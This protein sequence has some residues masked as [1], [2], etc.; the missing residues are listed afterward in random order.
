[1]S[2]TLLLLAGVVLLYA[3]TRYIQRVKQDVYVLPCPPTG[4]ATWLWGHEKR[5]FDYES[6]EM[7]TKWMIVLGPLYKIKAALFH[8]DVIVAA[9]HAAVQHIFQYSDKYVKSPVFRPP[10]ANL[11]GKGLVWAEGDDHKKQRRIIAPAFSQENIK[12]M[13]DDV[14]ECAEKMENTLTNQLLSNNGNMTVNMVEKT[15]ACTLDIIGRVAFGHDFDAGHSTESL[16]IAASWHHH[17]NMGLTFG[18]FVAPLLVRTFPWIVKLPI[19]TLQAQ[20]TTKL[21]VTKL[22]NRILGRAAREG[23][24]GRDILSLLL[25]A[26]KQE[27]KVEDGLTP[28]QIVD[29]VNTFIMVGHETTAGTTNFTL[30]QLA[31]NPEMQKRLREEVQAL[32][33]DLNYDNIQKLE[34]LDA[35]VKEGLRLHPAS[36]HTERVVLED[37]VIPLSTPIRTSDGRTLTSLQVKAGQIFHIPFT[38]MQTNPVVWGADAHEFRPE[39]WI[40]PGGVPAPKDLP[41]G[42][43]GLVAFCDGPR[44]CIG[45]R[46]AILELK[47]MLAT[48]V[49]SIEFG[50][51]D[52]R[53][54]Q[55]ISP[56]LQPVVDGQGGVL[57]L[58]LSLAPHH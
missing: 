8:D 15:S 30:L 52:A 33:Y 56:T 41:H 23:T 4:E 43:S 36:P 19:S 54:E 48:L 35:V 53:I 1:M 44:M 22:A 55:R 27:K 34:Y 46:L 58:K 45:Y 13:S 29:N 16:E 18:G 26:Q 7:Y 25:N 9:D 42:W 2:S 39:R 5:V 32:Q 31:R 6:N 57:P 28:S 17:V 21:I 49:R 51:T 3:L 11:L 40:T 50:E 47:V 12:G 10:V 24:Y 37:D 20:G 14:W 38:A